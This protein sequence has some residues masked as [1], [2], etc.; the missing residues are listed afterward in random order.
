MTRPAL[1]LVICTLNEGAA[2]G[3][4][5]AE[6]I[7]A[8]GERS[9]EII[10]VDDDSQDG[11]GDRVRE[12]AAR[13]PRVRLIERRGVRGL[14]SAAITGWDAA[15]GERLGV[16]DGDGQHDPAILARMLAALDAEAVD[17]VVASRYAGRGPSGLSGGRAALS[18]LGTWAVVLALGTRLSDPLSGCFIMRRDWYAGVRPRLSGVGFKILLDAVGSARARPRVAEVPTALRPRAGGTSKLDVRVIADAAALLV[19]KR[20]GGLLPTRLVLFAA[21]GVTGIAVQL[22][23][24]SALTAAGAPSLPA[25]A[26][27]IVTA[28]VWN[29]TWNN[30]LTFQD[31]RRRGRAWW[32]GLLAFCLACSV[33]G[34]WNLALFEGVLRLGAPRTLASLAGAVAA[35]L[36]NYL[37]ARWAAWGLAPRKAV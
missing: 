37:A 26:T 29:F 8:L 22:L 27:A 1:S 10:V 16:M 14:A 19:E 31:R 18:R 11:T 5:L 15:A 3:G 24:F 9:F 4:L 35:G 17:L 28:M 32:G 33:G 25:Q 6:T 12:V 21:V 13:D 23:S 20:T 34:L 36:W 7:G 30:L 2:I